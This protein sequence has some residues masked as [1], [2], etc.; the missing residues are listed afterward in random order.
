MPAMSCPWMQTDPKSGFS[1]PMIS[2]SNTLLPVPLRPNTASVSPRFTVRLIPFK[3]LWLPKDLCKSSTA[4]TDALPSSS[5]FPCLIAICSI[6]SI[7]LWE[8]YEDEFHQDNVGKDH[9][10]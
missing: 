10:Q 9:E 3:T 2:L 6:V 7:Y 8:K 1:R 5:A 4:R